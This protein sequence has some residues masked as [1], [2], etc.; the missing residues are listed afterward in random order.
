MGKS[1]MLSELKQ[2]LGPGT[3]ISCYQFNHYI[4]PL[5]LGQ[6]SLWTCQL[7]DYHFIK[8]NMTWSEAQKY[9]RKNYTDLATV[10]NMTDMKRL[11]NFTGDHDEAWIGLYNKTN[12]NRTWH[13]SL[14]GLEFHE[15]EANW[16]RNE[17]NDCFTEN[18][19]FINKNLSW[20][21]MLCNNMTYFLCYGENCNMIYAKYLM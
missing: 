12:A 20:G 13:W 4:C 16:S 7:Y 18:C 14:P 6:C 21:Y 1:I 17:P 15:N 10:S 5:F 19:G 2:H 9:C 8:E 11:H 3:L